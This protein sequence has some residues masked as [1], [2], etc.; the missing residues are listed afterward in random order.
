MTRDKQW[1][2]VETRP[3]KIVLRRWLPFKIR[4]YSY[5]EIN[6]SDVSKIESDTIWVEYEDTSHDDFHH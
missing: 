4:S 3:D 6:I 5:K 2:R 1:T